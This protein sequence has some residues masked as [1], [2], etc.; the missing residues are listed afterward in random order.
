MKKIE[1]FIIKSPSLSFGDKQALLE[2]L[3]S[4]TESQVAQIQQILEE[5]AREN[6]QFGEQ[7]FT[8]WQRFKSAL[9]LIQ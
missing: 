3:P 5:E 2:R 7:E 8:L 9:S 6:K 1:K 4:C